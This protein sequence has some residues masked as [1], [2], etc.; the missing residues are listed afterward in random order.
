MSDLLTTAQAWVAADPDPVTRSAGQAL[1]DAGDE[2]AIASHFD[3]RLHFGTA[4]LRAEL[5]PGPRRMNQAMIRWVTGGLGR[6]LIEQVEGARDQGVVIGHDARH[7][8][9]E[10][11]Q[12]AAAVLGALGFRVWLY[13]H[14]VATPTL[15]Y[16]TGHLKAAAGIMV[17]ASHNPPKDNGYKV[18][19]GNAA[20]IVPPHDTGIS[21]AIDALKGPGAVEVADLDTLRAE[22]RLTGVPSQVHVDYMEA[23]R[24]LRVHNP[25]PGTLKIVYTPMHGVGGD[26]MRKV[27]LVNG[28]TDLQF[29]PSQAE[30]DGDFPTVSFPNPEEPGALDHALA[31]ARE[32]KADLIIAND[33]DA[34]R[35]A[36]AIPQ[37][38][39]GGEYMVLTGNQI[40]AL[41]A[42]DLLT[43][44]PQVDGRLVVTTVV[45]SRM[46]SA[47][48]EAH[49]VAYGDTLTGFK[50][51]ANKALAHEAN[52]GT[53]V[54][55]YEEA[56]GFSA[57]PVVR[58]KDGVSS[59]LLFCDLAAHA[60]EG[61]VM[62]LLEA[63]YARHG[64][65][66]SMQ[67]SIVCPG[68]DGAAQIKAMMDTLRAHPPTE[69]AGTAIASTVD[70]AEGG[71]LPPSNVLIYKLEG[72]GQVLARPS[73][74]EPKIKFY[75]EINQPWRAGV[76]L[77]DQE[78]EGQTTLN[79]MADALQAA[80]Q[81]TTAQ[82]AG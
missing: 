65:Y 74:T 69:L 40:G 22:G 16:A 47:L 46:L 60:G 75:F 61:G 26:L 55:G 8:S 43:H 13:D 23:V 20:Q 50:W 38:E 52:G 56:L 77:A 76:P 67:R 71:E 49:G 17:T 18:Y 6:Y 72:G 79:T 63:L 73:G 41:L 51:I 68:D 21:A 66:V 36:V 44:G 3:G 5:G 30:P 82:S 2:A 35:L 45:S 29:V 59:A 57:G 48:A 4:G 19:W 24:A 33:P 80:A 62:G 10:F 54:M 14:L 12:E 53:F 64:L 11:A 81:P 15:A 27:L 39:P 31:L 28:H 1:L 25:E 37:G 7:G 58:D 70:L 32:I 78:A 9:P 42:D 34:D